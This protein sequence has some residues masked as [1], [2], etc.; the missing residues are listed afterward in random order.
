[1]AEGEYRVFDFDRPAQ[2]ANIADV[3][4]TSFIDPGP[5]MAPLEMSPSYQRIVHGLEGK[6]QSSKEAE[7]LQ[8]RRE[9]FKTK[10]D[11]FFKAVAARTGLLPADKEAPPYDA[12]FFELEA[13]TGTLYLKYGD[14][15]V[16]VTNLINPAKFLSL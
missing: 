5:A 2:D 14:R 1:M 4:E 11:A 6:L 8:I 3:D 12:L 10:V 7:I 9:L 16:R 15:R 13:T